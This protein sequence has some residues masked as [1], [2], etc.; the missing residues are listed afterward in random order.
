MQNYIDKL[1]VFAQKEGYEVVGSVPTEMK[2]EP[3]FTKVVSEK[4]AVNY[5]NG[6]TET[7][8]LSQWLSIIKVPENQTVKLSNGK[9]VNPLSKA[10]L[11]AVLDGT[12]LNEFVANE[13]DIPLVIDGAI[14]Y[15]ATA[16]LG[17]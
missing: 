10:V 16:K 7:K 15:I 17:D 12:P 9:T 14:T 6:K 13:K 5:G 1:A 11:N 8:T 3:N 2:S 4:V